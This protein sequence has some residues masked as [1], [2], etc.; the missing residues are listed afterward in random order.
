MKTYNHLKFGT[1]GIQGEGPLLM[2]IPDIAVL[3]LMMYGE[4]WRY[5]QKSI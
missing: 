1:R 4:V 2:L 5:R 3:V